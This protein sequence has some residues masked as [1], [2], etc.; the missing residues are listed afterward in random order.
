MSSSFSK[1]HCITLIKFKFVLIS[2]FVCFFFLFFLIVVIYHHSNKYNEMYNERCLCKDLQDL[3]FV[4]VRLEP[5]ISPKLNAHKKTRKTLC[6][7]CG[8]ELEK[9]NWR[10]DTTQQNDNLNA[11]FLLFLNINLYQFM[12]F[13]SL[14]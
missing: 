13:S 4:L 1:R 9:F 11:L 5:K 6:I 7:K 8:S 10:C 2:L 12:M 3:V 14:F